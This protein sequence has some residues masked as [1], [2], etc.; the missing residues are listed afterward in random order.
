MT[1][2]GLGARSSSGAIR[3]SPAA[4]SAR[5]AVWTIPSRIGMASLYRLA[6]MPT[7]AVG[8]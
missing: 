4:T 2:I 5:L 8:P 1:D 7:S 6:E 3:E